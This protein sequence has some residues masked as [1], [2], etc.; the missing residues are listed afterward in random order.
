MKRR[1]SGTRRARTARASSLPS[2]RCRTVSSNGRFILVMGE[3][4][5]VAVQQRVGVRGRRHVEASRPEAADHRVVVAQVRRTR[6]GPRLHQADR[7]SMAE[8][9]IADRDGPLAHGGLPVRAG[10]RHIDLAEDE[11]DDAVED[12][13]LVGEVVVERHRLDA[14]RLAELAHAERLEPAL[15]RRVSSRHRGPA[16]GSVGSRRCARPRWSGS[17]WAPSSRD[18]RVSGVDTF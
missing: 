3:A 13:L 4:V 15:D 7:P 18:R 17:S 5:D 16:P 1:G 14:E 2:R 6:V 10:Y 8:Q 9:G 12:S 11:V